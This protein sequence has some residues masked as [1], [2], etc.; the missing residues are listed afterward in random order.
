[1]P[2]ELKGN[3]TKSKTTN[4]KETNNNVK[5]LFGPPAKKKNPTGVY[6]SLVSSL[7]N[8]NNVNNVAN[9]TVKLFDNNASIEFLN[10]NMNKETNQD[11]AFIAFTEDIDSAIKVIVNKMVSVAQQNNESLE[12]YL[13]K[14][15]KDSTISDVELFKSF[16]LTKFDLGELEIN[17]ITTYFNNPENLQNVMNKQ[18]NNNLKDSNNYLKD[19]NGLMSTTNSFDLSKMLNFAKSQSKFNKD[20]KDIKKVS[21]KEIPKEK[22][23]R[24][25]TNETK[26]N[27]EEIKENQNEEE[28]SKEGIVIEDKNNKENPI[29]E[30]KEN[31]IKDDKEKL[32]KE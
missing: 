21:T 5:H 31:P 16:L 12:N 2:Q 18:S 10:N 28:K 22:L 11:N 9:M 27:L 25:N 8:L 3:F 24:L 1:L 14:Y 4:D 19:S 17:R 32:A 15:F 30:N 7:N 26:Q 6:G 29:K 20:N 13:G 23:E